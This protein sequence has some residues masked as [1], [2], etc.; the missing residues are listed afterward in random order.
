MTEIWA[1]VLLAVADMNQSPPPERRTGLFTCGIDHSEPCPP[2]GKSPGMQ[3]CTN[4]YGKSW[5][6]GV[7]I[8]GNSV[9]C[10]FTA[11]NPNAPDKE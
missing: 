10:Y 2:P 8:T 1:L 4:D 11:I 7:G 6:P 9:F 3:W 5:V